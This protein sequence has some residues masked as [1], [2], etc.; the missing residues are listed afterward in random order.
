[1]IPI[2]HPLRLDQLFHQSRRGLVSDVPHSF[3]LSISKLSLGIGS[4][5]PRPVEWTGALAKA[6]KLLCAACAAAGPKVK[7]EPLRLSS[8]PGLLYRFQSHD[9]VAAN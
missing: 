8:P 2:T 5:S 1:M 9:R 6:V 7:S 4:R 3:L